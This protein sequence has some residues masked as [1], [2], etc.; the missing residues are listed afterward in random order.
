MLWIILLCLCWIS[1]LWPWYCEYMRQTRG[2]RQSISYWWT[3]VEGLQGLFVLFLQIFYKL[4][5]LFF[6]AGPQHMDFLGQGSDLNCNCDLCRSCSNTGSFKTTVLGRELSLC[7]GTAEMSQ[8]SLCHSTN[9]LIFILTYCLTFFFA[10]PIICMLGIFC[11]SSVS[12][13]CF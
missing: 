7:P 2:E 13:E 8:I 6:L 9:S 5:I 1:W 10:I 4:E 3:W 11:L 12:I